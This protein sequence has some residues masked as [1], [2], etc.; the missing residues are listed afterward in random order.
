M[1]ETMIRR[2]TVA[3]AGAVVL[4]GFVGLAQA[5][6]DTLEGPVAVAARQALDKGDLQPIQIWVGQEQEKELRERFRQSLDVRKLGGEAKA[7][8]DL[9]FIETAVR[10]H[11]AAEGMP[12]TGLKPA[13][14]HPDIHAAEQALET[15]DIRPVVELLVAE[16]RAQVGKW[17]D[18]AR[19]ARQNKDRSVAA[20][21]EYVDAYVKY[22]TFV[23]GL[24]QSIHA[25]PEHGV[26]E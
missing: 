26:D 14:E 2:T 12:Y 11:R 16:L 3:V 24:H 13:E 15:G 5:H 10:L 21:R 6:C 23:H 25:G 17:F 19:H 18:Q 9:Y 7:M 22:V 4:I 20:G 1:N 8:A